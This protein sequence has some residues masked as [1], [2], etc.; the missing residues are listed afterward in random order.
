[1]LADKGKSRYNRVR[2]SIY[3]SPQAVLALP[4]PIRP[5]GGAKRKRSQVL[6]KMTYVAVAG[7]AL[8]N[9]ERA[10]QACPMRK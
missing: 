5:L 3:E 1:M 6:A 9:G 10:G 7:I 8:V 2:T 4:G